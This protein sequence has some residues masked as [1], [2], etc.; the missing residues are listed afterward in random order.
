[1]ETSLLTPPDQLLSPFS[2]WPE[3]G[4]P[5]GYCTPQLDDEDVEF[6]R[7]NGYLVVEGALS[8][9]E[10]DEIN[11]DAAEICRGKYGDFRGIVP[12]GPEDSNDDVLKRYLCIHFPDR[13][14]AVMAGYLAAEAMVSTLTRIIG[15]N[16]K[17]M[18]SMLFVK[19]SGKPGQAWHQDEYFIPTRD[20]S[21]VGGWIALDDA[22][23][24]NGCLWVLPGSHRDGIIWPTHEHGDKRFDCTSEAA[25]P[26]ADE[27][28]VPVEVRAGSIVFFNGYLLH[29][30]LPNRARTGYRRALVNHY[31]SAESLLPW[32]PPKEGQG[33]GDLDCRDIVMIAGTDPH[34]HRGIHRENA[35]FVR[36]SGEGG[37]VA[38]KATADGP[39]MG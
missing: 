26:F 6:F 29:R 13:C 34:A 11:R 20:R 25:F 1:M 35:T 14:S 10:V 3:S 2:S 18:Q 39:R 8:S 38:P 9:A 16:V 33:M 12:S 28:A 15:P 30:S 37:C 31:M 36:P 24:E 17:C 19:A 23:V 27:D 22:T 4:R 21:L 5:P 32:H 7:Q